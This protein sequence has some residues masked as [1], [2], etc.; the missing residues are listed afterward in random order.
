MALFLFFLK[1]SDMELSAFQ[2]FCDVKGGLLVG[3]EEDLFPLNGFLLNFF[4]VDRVEIRDERFSP[5][6]EGSA[7]RRYSSILWGRRLQSL[8]RDRQ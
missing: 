3:N 5:L 4:A 2:F 8:F 6:S 1:G 7:R